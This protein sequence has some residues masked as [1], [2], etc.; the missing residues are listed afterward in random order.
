MRTYSHRIY[1][2]IVSIGF[3]LVANCLAAH[4]AAQGRVDINLQDKKI[5]LTVT[6]SAEEVFVGTTFGKLSTEPQTLGETWRA[7]GE[8]L[9]PHL[10]LLADDRP[11]AGV[12]TSVIAPDS[13]PPSPVAM[14]VERA[15]YS[16]E[17]LYASKGVQPVR[18]TLQQ[19]ALS[20]ILF[21]PGNPWTASYLVKIMLGGILFQE[22]LLLES[23]RPL[24]VNLPLHGIDVTN[25]A[26]SQS[27]IWWD[28][29]RHGIWHILMGYDHLLFVSALALAA[30][31]LGDL[32][33]VITAFTVAHTLTLV[34]SVLNLVRLQAHFVEPMIAASIVFVALQNTFWPQTT[35]GW[36]RLGVA[37]AFGLF[38]GLGF[39]GGLLDAMTELPT[40]A[41]VSAIS[42]FSVGVEVG[43]QFVVIPVFIL[44]CLFRKE[45]WAAPRRAVLRAA[46]GLI[47]VAGIFFLL[48]ALRAA[49]LHG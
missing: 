4:P 21:A 35:Q 18:I 25:V 47:A 14:S 6:V 17:F 43:H 49:R 44:I 31:T 8:Y 19:D 20:E 28:Y 38:H 32:I 27:R 9:L 7:Y 37:F 40:T 39:A 1:D 3:I 34:L 5:L 12:L 10:R 46:S 30:V 29:F 36:S 41:M 15:V 48:G 26:L 11:L 33:K 23:R 22:G 16:F 13:A 2:W 42:A 24:T 45:N